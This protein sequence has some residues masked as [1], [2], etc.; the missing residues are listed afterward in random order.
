MI[1]IFGVQEGKEFEAADHLKKQLLTIWPDIAE[2]VD[3]HVKLFVGLKLYGY[4]IDI[5]I[6]M[7][8]HFATPRRFD[9]EFKFHPCD[10]DPFMTRFA[11]VKNFILVIEVKSHDATGVRFHDK[12]ASVRN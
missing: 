1:E 8:G 5:D 10:G 4:R 3:D 2:S 7:V 11:T 12:I 9:V 6:V